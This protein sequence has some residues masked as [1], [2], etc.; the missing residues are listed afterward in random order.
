[1]PAT[2]SKMEKRTC[3]HNIMRLRLALSHY[4]QIMHAVLWLAMHNALEGST[5]NAW[6]PSYNTN[7]YDFVKSVG[8]R[9]VVPQSDDK[10]SDC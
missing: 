7:S 4:A 8:S 6:E 3:H 10:D 9:V 5:K 1:M 2:L